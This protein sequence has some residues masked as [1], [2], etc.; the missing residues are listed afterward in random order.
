MKNFLFLLTV[1]SLVFSFGIGCSSNSPNG[2]SVS[3]D[4]RYA[5]LSFLA[6]FNVNNALF[7][8]AAS[9][10]FILE[11]VTTVLA[12]P[13]DT[14][15]QS[16]SVTIQ[17]PIVERDWDSLPSGEY[18]LSVESKTTDGEIVHDSSSTYFVSAGEHRDINW[19]INPTKSMFRLPILPDSI[20][21]S[22]GTV[23]LF[24]NG[25]LVDSGTWVPGDTL[26]LGNQLVD[27]GE[28]YDILV[29][30]YSDNGVR[31][32]EASGTVTPNATQDTPGRIQVTWDDPGVQ[33]QYG[34]ATFSITL[35]APSKTEIIVETSDQTTRE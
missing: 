25:A 3:N 21:D 10:S 12:G 9:D 16:D 27:V 4:D 13:E 34:S 33:E 5:S 7:K 35:I 20:P 32:G 1:L 28:E 18:T 15:T 6:T 24:L 23:K 22:V 30:F 2:P 8:K 29:V 31:M 14:I 11:T 19:S 26:V 17:D